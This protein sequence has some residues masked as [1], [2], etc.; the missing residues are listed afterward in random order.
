MTDT[1]VPTGPQFPRYHRYPQS[2]QIPQIPQIPYYLLLI[3]LW[4]GGGVKNFVPNIKLQLV[5]HL[6]LFLMISKTDS[7]Y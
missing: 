7:K 4:V 1:P 2:Q 6:L 5:E 3:I